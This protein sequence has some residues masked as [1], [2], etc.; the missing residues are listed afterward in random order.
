M[1]QLNCFIVINSKHIIIPQSRL[2]IFT[3]QPIKDRCLLLTTKRCVII[4]SSVGSYRSQ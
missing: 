4:T 2:N 1:F 3:S